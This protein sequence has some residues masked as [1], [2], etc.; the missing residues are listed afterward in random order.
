MQNSHDH[1]IIILTRKPAYV[2]LFLPFS[3]V[4]LFDFDLWN[5]GIT[6]CDFGFAHL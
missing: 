6:F 5:E 1:I 4:M 3:A 2:K